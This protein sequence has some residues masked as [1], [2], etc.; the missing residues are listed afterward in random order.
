MTTIMKISSRYLP[1]VGRRRLVK[2]GMA[3]IIASGL[4]P[5]IARA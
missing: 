4:A 5:T 1:A 2:A 3:G